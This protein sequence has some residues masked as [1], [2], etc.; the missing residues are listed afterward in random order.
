MLIALS[1]GSC[2]AVS[3]MWLW[4]GLQHIGFAL[5]P[6]TRMWSPTSLWLRQK[7]FL[8]WDS[9]D[10]CPTFCS[11]FPPH[12]CPGFEVEI[13]GW[14][15]FAVAYY[16]GTKNE[17][18]YFCAT[19]IYNLVLVKSC[20]LALDTRIGKDLE[21]YWDNIYLLTVSEFIFYLFF[22]WRERRTSLA[23]PS[24]STHQ[25][26]NNQTQTFWHHIPLK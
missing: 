10:S 24:V 1:E 7:L 25:N 12:H 8:R 17:E 22:V 9:T 18:C 13:H 4:T 11:C 21:N 14:F 19:W 26:I 23:E 15:I 6:Q 16:C 3:C 2:Q 5:P 20:K